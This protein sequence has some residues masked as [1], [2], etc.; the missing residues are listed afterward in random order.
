MPG[1]VGMGGNMGGK[2]F[3]SGILP[4]QQVVTVENLLSQGDKT[5]QLQG[6]ETV[7]PHKYVNI[8][9]LLRLESFESCPA[10]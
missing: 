5:T 2:Q 6:E 8:Y 4:G 9:I 10:L 7:E 1:S 3:I